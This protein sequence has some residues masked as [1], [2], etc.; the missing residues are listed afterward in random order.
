M[1]RK[2]KAVLKDWQYYHFTKNAGKLEIPRPP[3]EVEK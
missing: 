2:E 3:F 1:Y